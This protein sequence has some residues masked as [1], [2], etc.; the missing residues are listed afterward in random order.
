MSTEV[1]HDIKVTFRFSSDCQCTA[2]SSCSFIRFDSFV[3]W[4]SKAILS[5]TSFSG[6]RVHVTEKRETGERDN[7]DVPSG[8]GE[9]I[10]WYNFRTIPRGWKLGEIPI[11]GGWN[12]SKIL[13][14]GWNCSKIPGGWKTSSIGGGRSK[15]GT[16]PY[17]SFMKW[18]MS[19]FPSAVKNMA[20]F[21]HT[22][23]PISSS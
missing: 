10:F 6:S 11:P 22:N 18:F 2:E 9:G 14:G 20:Y 16:S 13:P 19:S 21:P 23:D 17:C 8:E 1:I 12:C 5:T 3:S 4:V 7:N 15:N